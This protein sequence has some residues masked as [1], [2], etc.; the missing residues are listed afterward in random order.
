MTFLECVNRILRENNHIRG[1][2]DP[3][4]S[5]DETQH[6]AVTN[7]AILAVQGELTDLVSDRLIPYERTS[8]T[9]TLTTNL[10][11]YDLASNFIR[12]YSKPLFYNSTVNRQ[13]YEYP[14]GL[15]RLRVE[16]YNY[17]SQYGQPNWWYWEP[18]TTKRVGFFQVP[19]GSSNGQLWTYEYEKS[20]AVS[21]VADTIPFH[22]FEEAITFT[23]MCSRRH[24]FMV[25]D[26]DNKAD[27][28]AILDGDV[29]YTRAKARLM[30]LIKGQNPK[31]KYTHVYV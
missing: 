3:I 14:G 2:T 18:T 16:I 31:R 22:N 7:L 26:T 8:G 28:Q 13:I 6:N 17:D 5:F 27:I 12:F 25:S 4:A 9:I 19:D 11:Y 15:E 10:R 23:S 20:V 1:D 24:K 21:N 30:N 29:S